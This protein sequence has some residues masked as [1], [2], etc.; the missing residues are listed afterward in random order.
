MFTIILLIYDI[1]LKWSSKIKPFLFLEFFVFFLPLPPGLSMGLHA[2]TA[3]SKH[4]SFF[5]SLLF[6]FP[7]LL[8]PSAEKKKDT[9]NPASLVKLISCS[10]GWLLKSRSLRLEICALNWVHHLALDKR[11]LGFTN[12]G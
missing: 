6:P 2:C 8:F 5:L 10:W 11:S 3:P 12:F 7:F 4:F 9:C 1:Y